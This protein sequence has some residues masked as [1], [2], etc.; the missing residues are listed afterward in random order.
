MEPRGGK[1]EGRR[2]R[3]EGWKDAGSGA[4]ALDPVPRVLVAVHD[5]C[6]RSAWGGVY[7]VLPPRSLREG[8]EDGFDPASR[9]EAEHGA[10]VV[11]QVEL[12]VAAAAELLPLLLLLGELHVLPLGDDGDVGRA[13]GGEAVLCEGRVLLGVLVVLVIEEDATQATP[14]ATVLD[15]EVIVGPGL[16]AGVVAW[17]VLVADVLVGAVEV[18]HVLLKEVGRSDVRSTAEP[19][20]AL[21]RLEVAVVEVHGGGHGIAG[22][23]DGGETDGEEGHALTRLQVLDAHGATLGSSTDGIR[24]EVSIDDG[25]TAACLLEHCAVLKNARVA[26]ATVRAFPDILS[27]FRLSVELLDLFCDG[28]LGLAADLFHF[29]AHGLV[30]LGTADHAVRYLLER[31]EGLPADAHIGFSGGG[32]GQAAAGGGT[33]LGA[34]YGEGGAHEPEGTRGG[35]DGGGQ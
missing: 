17:V 1:K 31:L 30:A 12:Y 19:P 5:L 32:H 33:C 7:V 3:K 27:E 22:V 16:E 2:K 35:G 11:H 18:L 8:H 28:E 34:R 4:V 14:L 6:L 21:I 25:E 24:R 26:A 29:A 15:E 9:L 23:H 13:D 10:S 20:G